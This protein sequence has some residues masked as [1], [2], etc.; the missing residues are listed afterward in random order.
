MTPVTSNPWGHGRHGRPGGQQAVGGHGPAA[1]GSRSCSS[2]AGVAGRM[3]SVTSRHG[4][5]SWF[6]GEQ[7]AKFWADQGVA[8]GAGLG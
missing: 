1:G 6:P 8:Y 2:A 4:E 5:R 7:R 3:S